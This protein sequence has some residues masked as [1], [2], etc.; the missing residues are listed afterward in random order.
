M[1][2]LI[3]FC[4]LAVGGLL[5]VMLNQW[6]QS[7]NMCDQEPKQKLI[8]NIKNPSN[9]TLESREG[10][11]RSPLKTKVT[12]VRKIQYST[13][14]TFPFLSASFTRGP[15]SLTRASAM[16]QSDLQIPQESQRPWY[17][18]GGQLCPKNSVINTTTGS[19]NVK[20]FADE[21]PGED[22]VPGK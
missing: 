21:L 10:I 13:E 15:M 5:L 16:D 20:I 11:N 6:T 2:K 17:M 12:K 3:L 1:K 8:R 4:L 18:A 22:R 7:S 9:Q 14:K 19:R